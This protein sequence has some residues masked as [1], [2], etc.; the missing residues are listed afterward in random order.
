LWHKE[1]MEINFPF[2][3]SKILYNQS[4]LLFFSFIFACSNYPNQ[5]LV[6]IIISLITI[7]TPGKPV[8]HIPQC[9][10][11]SLFTGVVKSSAP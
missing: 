2:L 1:F 8:L 7:Y 4:A 11:S 6:D 3:E 5:F 10:R 9:Q